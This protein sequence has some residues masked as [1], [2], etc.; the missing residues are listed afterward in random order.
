VGHGFLDRISSSE[1]TDW[2]SY[3]ELLEYER[4]HPETPVVTWE[5]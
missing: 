3:L 4:Q 1:L 5:P 2:I